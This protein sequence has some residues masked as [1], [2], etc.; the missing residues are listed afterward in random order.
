VGFREALATSIPSF[1]K[2]FESWDTD[3][4]QTHLELMKKFANAARLTRMT[5]SGFMES[6]YA[7]FHRSLN[8]LKA[9]ARR[10]G[11]ILLSY[12]AN[13]Q[14]TV[15]RKFDSIP[16]RLTRMT[17]SSFVKPPLLQFHRSLNYL[18]TETRTFGRGVLS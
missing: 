14:I 3:V 2:L 10:F 13:M 17:K 7:R 12:S 1:V 6:S 9:G 15:S 18:R 11:T 5:K 4:R 16:A 8:Y